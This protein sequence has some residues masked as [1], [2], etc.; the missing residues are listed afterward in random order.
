MVKFLFLFF[1]DHCEWDVYNTWNSKKNIG[2]EWCMEE[3]VLY[4]SKQ[5]SKAGKIKVDHKSVAVKYFG[6]GWEKNQQKKNRQASVICL[7]N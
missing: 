6:K 2:K 5:D 1:L 7:W 3:A 4:Y